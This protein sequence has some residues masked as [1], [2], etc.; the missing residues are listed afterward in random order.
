MSKP[1][2]RREKGIVKALQNVGI[3]Y[4]DKNQFVMDYSQE[5]F[6]AMRQ[7]VACHLL[8]LDK[9][10]NRPFVSPGLK[11]QMAGKF[12]MIGDTLSKWSHLNLQN[13]DKTINSQVS[14]LLEERSTKARLQRPVEGFNGRLI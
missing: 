12:R 6:V 3:L 1:E 4:M 13:A 14:I 2:K 10:L 7:E 5:H 11:E 9:L 8:A